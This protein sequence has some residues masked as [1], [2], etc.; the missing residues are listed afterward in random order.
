MIVKNNLS[1]QS[2]YHNSGNFNLINKTI[3]LKSSYKLFSNSSTITSFS[4]LTGSTINTQNLL[5]CT[6]SNL[7][8]SAHTATF[9][10]IA[11]N[12]PY[13]FMDIM[14]GGSA[15][16]TSTATITTININGNKSARF[17][18]QDFYNSP[19]Y[20]SGNGCSSKVLIENLVLNCTQL[21]FQTF[22]SVSNYRIKHWNLLKPIDIVFENSNNNLKLSDISSIT[23]ATNACNNTNHF[24]SLTNQIE[25]VPANTFTVNNMSFFNAKTTIPFTSNGGANIGYNNGINF[26]NSPILG[27]STSTWNGSV[28]TDIKNPLNWTPNCLPS[29]LNNVIVPGGTPNRIEIYDKN[30]ICYHFN[31]VAQPTIIIINPPNHTYSGLVVGGNF[32]RSAN[33]VYAV[34]AE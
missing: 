26:I 9:N 19:I 30:L 4:D 25:I 3:N 23:T 24:I 21:Y 27:A 2:L 22:Q 11:S 28:S 15:N 33:T 18:V 5:I 34:S 7:N 6:N 12:T 32:I 10:L 31:A 16:A 17:H 20:L 29:I 14:L 13:P 8:F 1:F